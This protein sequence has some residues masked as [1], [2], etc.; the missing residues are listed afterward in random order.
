[1][2]TVVIDLRSNPTPDPE[3]PDD[4][5]APSLDRELLDAALEG[6]FQVVREIGRGATGVVYLARDLALHRMVAIKALRW[7]CLS[8]EEE[9]DRFRREARTTGQ[10]SHPNIVALHTFAETADAMY[11]VLGWVDG[12]SLADRLRREPRLPVAEALPIILGV[13]SALA[14]AHGEGLVHRDLKPEN[15]LIDRRSGR[16]LLADFGVATQPMR[17]MGMN[18]RRRSFGTPHFM[19]PEQAAGETEVDARSDIFSLGVL[20]YTMLSG[21]R[22]FDAPTAEALAAQQVSAEHPPL[23][24][25]APHVPTA[26]AAAVER[27]MEK[28]P[29][30]RWRKVEELT[31]AL[32]SAPADGVGARLLA[33]IPGRRR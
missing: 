23:R 26:V 2:S 17:D 12:G 1:M 15:V 8:D 22:P 25:V 11:M 13:A 5:G 9:R 6:R 19:S 32:E 29:A 24:E 14:H 28:E 10:L 16:A 18:G 3:S 33:L 4:A 30:A 20:A 27:C 7:E 31:A 21:R